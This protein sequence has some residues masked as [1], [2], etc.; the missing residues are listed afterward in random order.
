MTSFEESGKPL[1]DAQLQEVE[2]RIGVKLPEQYRRFLQTQNGGRPSPDHFDF[3]ERP[4]QGSIVDFLYGVGVHRRPLELERRALKTE[5]LPGD[6]MEIGMDP[7][8][9]QICIGISGERLGKVYFWA[10]AT[11][12]RAYP[13]LVGALLVADSF[14][15]FLAGLRDRTGA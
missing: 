15:E 8:G 12:H 10:G 7:G 5:N 4:G 11:P 2:E 13:N 14:D 6:L 1:S 3:R 9:S